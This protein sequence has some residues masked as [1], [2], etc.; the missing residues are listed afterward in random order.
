[1]FYSKK[2]VWCN[3]FS[4]QKKNNTILRTQLHT[5]QMLIFLKVIWLLVSYETINWFTS[6]TNSQY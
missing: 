3:E 4:N 1:M 2:I 6:F 5:T